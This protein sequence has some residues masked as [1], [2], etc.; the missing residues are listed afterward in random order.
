[1]LEFF[2]GM[3]TVFVLALAGCTLAPKYQR[4]TTAYA[5]TWPQVPGHSENPT[6]AAAV[7]AADIGWREFFRDPRLQRLIELALTNNPDLRVA[8]LNVE[9]SRA[10]YRIQRAALLP[11][12]DATGSGLRQRLP[13]DLSGFT[14]PGGPPPSPAQAIHQPFAIFG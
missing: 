5:P 7:P 13:H 2:L 8:S 9:L 1:M 14:T 4:P 10:Q 12:I 6:V 11:A 3:L